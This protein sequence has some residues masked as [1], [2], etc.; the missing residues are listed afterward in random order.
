M[1]PRG[2]RN[3]NPGNIE[4]SGWAIR[5]SGYIG[6]EPAGRFAT[7]D[8]MAHGI[9]ALIRL[10]V[11]YREQGVRSVRAIISKWAPPSENNTEAYLQHVARDLGVSADEELR[12]DPAVYRALAVAIAAFECGA[13]EFAAAASDAEIESAV[14]A[15]F[16]RA[17][18]EPADAWADVR[19]DAAPIEDRS[20]PDP[21]PTDRQQ[22]RTVEPL[23]IVAM[24]ASAAAKLIP[25]FGGLLDSTKSVPERNI[26]VAQRGMEVISQA[27]GALNEQDAL[28][29]IKTSPDALR[30]ATAAI[31]AAYVELVEIG[32][33]LQAAR[34]ADAQFVASKA[35]VWDSPSFRI[36]CMMLPLIY[37]PVMSMIFRFDFLPD[38][39]NDA[40]VQT[41]SFVIGTV[42]GGIVGY[43]FGMMTSRNR[44]PAAGA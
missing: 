33:G 43:Y 26:A 24:L 32:G 9:E 12:D 29:K 27:V 14:S 36:A 40:R 42:L 16:G 3:R 7:F 4:A 15:V 2:I 37:L 34:A 6:P 44:T 23:S 35:S 10:L 25:V 39:T 28:E 41:V 20:E 21:N 22:E 8:T 1:T 18:E 13:Q 5:Q 38:W 11:R 30:T 19:A 31:N 17:K